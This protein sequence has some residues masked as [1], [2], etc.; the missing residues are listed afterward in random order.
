MT[1]PI[2]R[3][4]DELLSKIFVY[5]ISPSVTPE[6]I[7]APLN[8]SSVCSAWRQIATST[9]TLW[10]S[11]MIA[12]IP[13]RKIRFTSI[14]ETWISRSQSV[15]FSFTIK[16]NYLKEKDPSRLQ[17]I[18]GVLIEHCGLWRNINISLR[19][20]GVQQ[21]FSVIPN[22][23][24]RIRG[25]CV[26]TDMFE[27][28]KFFDGPLIYLEHLSVTATSAFFPNNDHLLLDNLRNLIL[29]MMHPSCFMEFVL[30]TPR[31]ET[32]KVKLS[33]RQRDP[34][35]SYYPNNVI[36]PHLRALNITVD[37]NGRTS[38]EFDRLHESLKLPALQTLIFTNQTYLYNAGDTLSWHGFENI[39]HDVAPTLRNLGIRAHIG[40][41]SIPLPQILET[42]P[43]LRYLAISGGFLD[44]QLIRCLT[45]SS[46]PT[47]PS[48]SRLCP[49]LE[50]LHLLA[51]RYEEDYSTIR[52]IIDMA[53]MDK[54]PS[55]RENPLLLVFPGYPF[56]TTLTPPPNGRLK[57]ITEWKWKQERRHEMYIESSWE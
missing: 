47:D 3:L 43:D 26:D 46:S 4:P 27:I 13:R 24:P 10:S 37:L 5:S 18:L 22:L 14:I 2:H 28:G 57:L 32:A 38:F 36:L 31:L 6:Q 29:D 41:L 33:F 35:E 45:H 50:T 48:A 19:H 52:S 56:H 9:P 42:H 20:D 7:Q 25:I 51:S 21:I 44:E 1:S 34:Q 30:R 23:T 39:L 40:T 12:V 8:I 16:W 53:S 49:N 15:G 54:S 55:T 11:I 17:A